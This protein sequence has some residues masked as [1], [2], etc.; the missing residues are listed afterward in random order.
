[1]FLPQEIIRKV[2]DR[3]PLRDEEVQE[4]A[5]GIRAGK[6]ADSQVAAFAMAVYFNGL[7]VDEC[8]AL[9]KA[10]RDSGDVLDWSAANL[11][12]PTADKHSTGGIGDLTSLLLGPMVAACGAYVP[13]ISG[14]GLGHTGGTLDKLESIPG[15]NISQEPQALRR[16]VK[17]AGVAIVG[18]TAKLTPVEKKFYEIRDIT[19]T[20]ESIPL[21]TAAIV[22]K[23][24]AAGASGFVM[25]VKVGSGAF[26]PTYE[27]S[28]ALA[29]SIAHIGNGAGMQTTT[30]LTDM[31][32]PLVSCAGNALEI[33]WAIDYLTGKH[34]PDRLHEVVMTLASQLLML[35]KL[36]DTEDA[37]RAMLTKALDSGEAAV[38]FARMVSE[39]GGPVDLLERPHEHLAR[40]AI[41]APIPAPSE[42]FVSSIDARA[43]GIAI[44]G[45]GGGR[46]QADDKIDYSVGLSGLAEIGQPVGKHQ[47]LG[48]VHARNEADAQRAIHAVQQAYRLSEAIGISPPTIYRIIA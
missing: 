3:I 28:V 40:A 2:R 26:M 46:L 21:I 45:L 16:V 9:T 41:V 5:Q 34:R 38:R 24:L 12:G 44:I 6:V 29:K 4:F 25:D 19:A 7:S 8:V 37:A 31:S 36:A 22:S 32:Q 1:M 23:K 17:N 14:R 20:V 35:V 11:D 13:M 48:L 42:G 47:P 10:F 43:L 27:D 33:A 15:Y 39:L 30:V 18:Q